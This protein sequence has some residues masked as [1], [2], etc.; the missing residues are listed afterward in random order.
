MKCDAARRKGRGKQAVPVTSGTTDFAN[1]DSMTKGSA[2]GH[3]DVAAGFV[4]RRVYILLLDMR[5]IGFPRGHSSPG[6]TPHCSTVCDCGGDGRLAI[7][8]AT[9]GCIPADRE[10]PGFT[11]RIDGP[12]VLCL[13]NGQSRR[14]L[15]RQARWLF[16][17][18]F[19]Y[20]V[21]DV[22]ICAQLLGVL[23]PNEAYPVVFHGA[24]LL[25]SRNIQTDANLVAAKFQAVFHLGLQVK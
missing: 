8:P 22:R 4:M 23:T 20:D 17:S 13:S 10:R 14:L 11:I 3:T 18:W 2:N 24:A 19:H 5:V 6:I 25:L 16:P 12:L 21:P 9:N 15:L 7:Y 1:R